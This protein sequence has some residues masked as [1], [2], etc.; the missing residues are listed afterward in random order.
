M[1]IGVLVNAAAVF[2]GGILGALLK[3]KMPENLKNGLTLIFGVSALGMG[4]GSVMLMQNM[5]AVI[6]SVIVG[7]GIGLLIHLG[8]LF[9]KAGTMLAKP[10]SKL[11]GGQ[12]GMSDEDRS[13]LVTALVL[14]C[15]SG[16]GIYGAIDF[17]MTGEQGILLSKS[18]LDIF[19]AMIFAC[20]LGFVT[21]AIAIPQVFIFLAMFYLA[22]FIYPHTTPGMINDFRAC[23]GFLLLATGIRIMKI[24]EIPIAD[25]IPAMILVMPVSYLWSMYILPLIH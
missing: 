21:A 18:I 16:T 5:P 8:D 24:K 7:T 22:G 12:R 10:F 20:S 25:M 4:I 11:G 1:P 17:G 3:N 23:G 2:V 14:F 19:T 13:L 15:C 6:F 9:A